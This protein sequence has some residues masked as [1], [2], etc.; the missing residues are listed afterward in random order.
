MRKSHM[1][2]VAIA[3]LLAVQF[4]E[5]A[6]SG[7][8]H[9]RCVRTRCGIPAKY[10]YGLQSP[11]NVAVATSGEAILEREVTVNGQSLPTRKRFVFQ[12][13]LQAGPLKMTG[14]EAVLESNGILSL[15]AVLQHTGG[16]SG[17]LLGGNA[18]VTV[19]ALSSGSKNLKS[20]GTVIFTTA[21]RIWV[22]RGRLEK[23]QLTS[24]VVS[25]VRR[26]F[27]DVTNLQVYLEQYPRR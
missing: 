4:G 25:K 19:H 2:L 1:A 21:K 11:D 13:Q 23:I 15:S 7:E 22:K 24:P 5:Y 17:S 26:S 9:V 8:F 12:K 3:V 27:P 14:T 10:D 6:L 20:R 16:D 18:V